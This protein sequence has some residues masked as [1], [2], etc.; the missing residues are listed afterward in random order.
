MIKTEG[1]TNLYPAVDMAVKK[2]KAY[3][4]DLTDDVKKRIMC[5]TDG[6]G[7]KFYVILFYLIF[8]LYIF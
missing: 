4:T 5:F 3:S 8:N 7:T 6:G 1:A 2:L